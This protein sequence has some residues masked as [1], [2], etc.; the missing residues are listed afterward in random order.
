MGAGVTIVCQINNVFLSGGVKEVM[1]QAGVI[2]GAAAEE[3]DDKSSSST[4]KHTSN[5]KKRKDKSR[6][7]EQTDHEWMSWFND[8]S[9]NPST[10]HSCN[11]LFIENGS[12]WF[13]N[14]PD[15]DDSRTRVLG[16]LSRDGC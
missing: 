5:K 2:E 12:R 4:T 7:E 6:K 11:Q 13:R 1:K 8:E 15:E 10:I 16:F 3:D 14:D 9:I